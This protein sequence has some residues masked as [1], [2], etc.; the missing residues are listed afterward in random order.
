M[1]RSSLDQRSVR[2]VRFGAFEVDLDADELHRNGLK[3]HRQ[4]QPFQVLA[5]LLE[6]PSAIATREELCERL[7]P[8]GTFVEFDLRRSASPACF[9]RWWGFGHKAALSAP[10][11]RKGAFSRPESG[12]V[13]LRPGGL[14]S[15]RP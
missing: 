2:S 11:P 14:F 5:A 4:D 10:K 1:G 9:S 3:V 8:E 13:L 6:R 15:F 12:L 7:W